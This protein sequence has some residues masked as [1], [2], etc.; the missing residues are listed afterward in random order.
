[1]L[2]QS[3][4]KCSG[5]EVVG[6]MRGAANIPETYNHLCVSAAHLR[7]KLLLAPAESSFAYQLESFELM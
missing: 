3:A 5:L 2:K 7:Q 1:M 6:S 4:G